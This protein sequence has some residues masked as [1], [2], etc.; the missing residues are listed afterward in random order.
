[1]V[2]RNHKLMQY[3]SFGSSVVAAA[4]VAASVAKQGLDA[5]SSVGAVAA[6]AGLGRP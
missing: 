5:V 1:M 2:A 4:K 6:L 3:S